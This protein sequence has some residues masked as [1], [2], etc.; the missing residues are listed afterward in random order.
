ME[1]T[2]IET[3]QR[4]SG[5]YQQLMVLAEYGSV[6]LARRPGSRT[7]AVFWQSQLGSLDLIGDGRE[8]AGAVEA[9]WGQFRDQVLSDPSVQ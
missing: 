9:V 5:C 1:K 4:E 8:L 2:P 3:L 6:T 7:W